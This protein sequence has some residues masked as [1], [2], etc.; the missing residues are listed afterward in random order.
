MS[1]TQYVYSK[2]GWGKQKVSKV[3]GAYRP[4]KIILASEKKT[5]ILSEIFLSKIQ[6][7]YST[8]WYILM[9]QMNNLYVAVLLSEM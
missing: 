4:S 8:V 5:S 3:F 9:A 1:F 7:F 2:R 6:I